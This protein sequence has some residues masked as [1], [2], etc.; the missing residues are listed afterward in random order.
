MTR[1]ERERLQ[2]ISTVTQHA[3][4][5][6]R[7]NG[8][9]STTLD[10]LAESSE[11]TKKTIYRYF[12]C[13][14]DLY[15]AVMLKGHTEL[16]DAIRQASQSGGD[17]NQ[18]IMAAYSASYEFFCANEWL[19]DLIAQMG[20]IRQKKDPEDLPYYGKYTGR[21]EQIYDEIT[22]LFT[23]AGADGSIRRDLD[24][25]QAGLLSAFILNGLFHMIRLYGGLFHTSLPGSRETL[26]GS[27]FRWLTE[28][29]SPGPA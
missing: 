5:L 18:R 3:E 13:K 2:L 26:I 4:D 6:F 23:A 21:L 7:Q 10:A 9:E 28:A 14:E 19:Y 15:F 11:Y 1:Q 17:G 22:A 20:S 27:A 29:L 8:Y 24:T 25:Q 12:A 16:L